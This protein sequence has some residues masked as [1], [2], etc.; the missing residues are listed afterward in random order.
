M[1]YTEIG[2][3]N[4]PHG[5]NG[6]LKA[7]IDERFWNDISEAEAFFVVLHG[8]KAPFFIEYF[9]GKGSL[10][11][12]FEDIE[13]KEDASIFTHKRLFMRAD[14]ISLTIAEIN[15][16]GLE[17][18]FL[19]W[20]E[21]IDTQ[22]GEAGIIRSVEEYPQQEMASVDYNGKISLIPLLEI[23]IT[24]INKDKKI[25]SMSLPN[26]LFEI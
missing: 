19:E 13:S 12:K 9:R 2:K 23:W 14:D 20:Y 24:S 10:I 8:D 11:L 21:L 26:G 25:I 1:E 3:I 4:K 6:E 18:S 5:L 17:Y 16:T 15:N 22:S 7:T